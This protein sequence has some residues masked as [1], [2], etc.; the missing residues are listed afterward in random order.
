MNVGQGIDHLLIFEQVERI[1]KSPGFK[2]SKILSDF[3]KF[4][5]TETLSGNELTL[6][7]YVIATNVLK[8]D[9]DFNPQLDAI[10]RIHGRRLRHLLD[11]YYKTVRG[12]E[13][14]KISIPKGRYI[15]IFEPNG[16]N[17]S[18][19]S[20]ITRDSETLSETIP[21]IALMPFKNYENNKRV[22]VICSVLCQE[23]N[24][25]LSRFP[26]VG[27]I[28]GYS[29]QVAIESIDLKE[30]VISHLG[31]D[32][33]ITGS[34]L[35]DGKDLNIFFELHSVLKNQLI[36]AESYQIEDYENDRLKNFKIIVKKVLSL[37]CGY[38]GIIYR[39]ILNAHV[40]QGYDYVYAVYW[41]NRYHESFSE[42]A[43]HEA[44]TAIEIALEKNP[45]NPLLNSFKAQLFLDLSAMDVQGEINYYEEGFNFAGKAL[46][47]DPN[48]QHALQ[49][50][51]WAYIIGH[52]KDKSI[53][54]MEKC[55]VINPNNP[56]YMT[57]IGFGYICI[58][59][60]EKGLELMSES[61]K[62]NPFS[63]WLLGVGFSL[64]FLHKS[65]FQE[66]YYW[67]CKIK[68]PGLIWDHILCISANGLLSGK[69]DTSKAISELYALS[70]NFNERAPHIVDTFLLDKGLQN[71]ILKGLKLS[72][73]PIQQ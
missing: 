63:F 6:K 1:L 37:T 62:L 65:D 44:F 21:L 60:Y 33:L 35:L 9:T 41:H 45:N 26:E 64:Y 57:I 42:E 23:L 15:P 71:T 39:D 38:L 48:N 40:P 7:E 55:L 10:V 8:K 2:K 4:I 31:A 50:M 25:G 47:L 70:P 11:D 5:V 20:A 53:Q 27:V 72:G 52:V 14:I 17:R 36:W 46:Q 13:Q 22:E 29:T 61:V 24:V 12:G 28:S 54:A 3:L 16:E 18:L 19:K 56:M 68:R 58:G 34:C 69:V 49:V 66:A 32:Y 51:A 73:L 30:K 59:N 43:F 67:A